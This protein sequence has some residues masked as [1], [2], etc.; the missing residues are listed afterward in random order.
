MSGIPGDRRVVTVV[1]IG[2]T[3]TLP[4]LWHPKARSPAS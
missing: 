1:A 4:L 3:L 2:Y